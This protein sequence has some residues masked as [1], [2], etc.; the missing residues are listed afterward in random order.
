MFLWWATGSLRILI[1]VHSFI[2]TQAQAGT[3]SKKEQPRQSVLW[4]W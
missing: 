1:N 3:A 2:G 4:G